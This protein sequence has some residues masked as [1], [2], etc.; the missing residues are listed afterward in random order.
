MIGSK[1]A[2]VETKIMA[3]HKAAGEG[4]TFNCICDSFFQF[5]LGIRIKTVADSQLVNMTKLLDY[6]P[7]IDENNASMLGPITVC[8]RG[9]W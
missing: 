9:L 6:L 2:D 4:P 1:A 7:Q 5:V 8:D 3:D